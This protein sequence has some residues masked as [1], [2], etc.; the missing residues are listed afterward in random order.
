MCPSGTAYRRNAIRVDM[1]FVCMFAHPPHSLDYIH[2]LSRP[3]VTVACEAVVYQRCHVSV[4]HKQCCQSEQ[5]LSASNFPPAPM[6]QN[7]S[8]AAIR[9]HAALIRKNINRETGSICD[10]AYDDIVLRCHLPRNKSRECQQRTC[11]KHGNHRTRWNVH[12][13]R[14]LFTGRITTCI[15]GKMNISTWCKLIGKLVYTCNCRLNFA[16]PTK[17]QRALKY[18]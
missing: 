3:S 9:R 16:A 2:G 12:R 7:N 18:F 8:G 1:Q 13:R 14:A 11:N 5:L 15:H 17:K 4:T 10:S 6:N